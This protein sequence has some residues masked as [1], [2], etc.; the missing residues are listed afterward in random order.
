MKTCLVGFT[1]DNGG[2]EAVALA[3]QLAGCGDAHIVVCVVTP[4][5]WGYPSLANVDQEYGK[6]LDQYAKDTLDQARAAMGDTPNVRYERVLAPSATVGLTQA[7]E[8]EKADI[9]VLGS[10]R[11]GA[12]GRLLLG[13][14]TD[15]LLH[16]AAVPIA[17]APRGFAATAPLS[18]VTVAYSG[19][20][21]GR[22]T[23]LHALGLAGA[24]KLPLRVVSFAVRDRQM[25]P[26]LAAYNPEEG[27]INGWL[28]QAQAALKTVHDQ[29]AVTGYPIETDVSVGPEWEDALAGLGWQDG[30][31]LM[32]GSSR[33][34][35][36][37][38]VFLG[39]NAAKILRA[40]PV[41]AIVLPRQ[42]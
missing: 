23:V 32:L 16:V 39:S 27:V 41:P 37:Q 40:S 15:E 11:D 2:Q 17:I 10:A 20:D 38:R 30:E 24:L 9:I 3:K 33:L 26:S 6:F 21:T 7:A 42:G 4:E 25:F 28:E 1:P 31:L 19:G 13:G 14:V 12:V 36:L 8:R 18:R 34:G 5:V 35:A 22:S 29:I